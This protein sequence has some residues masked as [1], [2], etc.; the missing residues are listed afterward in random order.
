MGGVEFEGGD[1]ADFMADLLGVESLMVVDLR[2]EE[3]R[4]GY[5][6]IAVAVALAVTVA[7]VV[8]VVVGDAGVVGV[9]I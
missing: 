2:F 6:F 1:G 4:E 7:S 9:G 3:P 5:R 8:V